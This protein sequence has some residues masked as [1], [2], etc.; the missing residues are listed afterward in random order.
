[1]A[2]DNAW[3]LRNYIDTYSLFRDDYF[4]EVAEGVIK[5][6]RETLSDPEGGFYASQDADVTHDDEGG[7][8]TWKDED[9]RRVLG[10]EEYDVL[11]LHLF[12]ER[13]SMHHNRSK[14]FFLSR[15]MRKGLL[16]RQ[17]RI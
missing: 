16:R 15:W 1:M 17:E 3:L 12:H 2:D 5:F 8:F 10:D 13:G 11:S 9:L 14:G 6:I 4:R 7:Y